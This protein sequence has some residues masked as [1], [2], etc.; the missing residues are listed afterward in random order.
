[1]KKAIE[2]MDKS[3][4]CLALELPES[5]H[6]DVAKTWQDVKKALSNTLESSDPCDYCARKGD[7]ASC[8]PCYEHAGFKGIKI[9]KVP[10]E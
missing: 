1:M 10:Q 7:R 9:I 4:K 3:V 2:E 5:V 6:D 8:S